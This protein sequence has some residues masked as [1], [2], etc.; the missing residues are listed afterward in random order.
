MTDP[1]EVLERMAAAMFRE[2]VVTARQ[3]AQDALREL[4]ELHRKEHHGDNA[5]RLLDTVLDITELDL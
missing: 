2:G 3:K 5:K 4:V 1:R